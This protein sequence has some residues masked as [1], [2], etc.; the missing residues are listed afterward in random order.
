MDGR[1]G[2]D[3]TLEHAIDAMQAQLNATREAIS[4]ELCTIPPPV[5]A[6]DVNFNRLLEDRARI[7]DELQRLG[8]LRAA[9]A[10]ASELLAFCRASSGLN[11]ASKSAIEALLR[12]VSAEH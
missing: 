3:V 4:R 12:E 8:R 1:Q 5:P 10:G 11:A 6:C 2:S 7:V 9:H